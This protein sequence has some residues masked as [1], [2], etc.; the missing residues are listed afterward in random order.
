[1]SHEGVKME[2]L[3]KKLHLVLEKKQ[4]ELV[5]IQRQMDE[6]K[7][8]IKGIEDAIAELAPTDGGMN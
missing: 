7:A 5:P 4:R 1:M 2:E 8:Y 3:R 6:A